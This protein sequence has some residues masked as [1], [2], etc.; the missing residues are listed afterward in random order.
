MILTV[1]HSIGKVASTANITKMSSGNIVKSS[2]AGHG[3]PGLWF[4]PKTRAGEGRS[5]CPASRAVYILRTTALLAQRRMRSLD[6][7]LVDLNDG[8][9]ITDSELKKTKIEKF[10]SWRRERASM[11]TKN[12]ADRSGEHPYL[13]ALPAV[14]PID[15]NLIA[16]N[17]W[18]G[19][20]CQ[21]AAFPA[22]HVSI[23]L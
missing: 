7:Q 10:Q 23:A 4:R 19:S 2:A 3:R 18:L 5:E 1:F 13:V 6:L 22:A 21:V 9:Y 17:S 15:N 8:Q 20:L 12:N 16:K 14:A 11:G